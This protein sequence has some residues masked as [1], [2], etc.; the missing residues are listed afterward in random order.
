MIEIE[1]QLSKSKIFQAFRR[2][3]K[4][5]GNTIDA[6]L[7][8]TVLDGIRDAYDKSKLIIKYIPE[9][10]LHDGAHLFR[11]LYKMEKLVPDDNMER[12]S[13]PDLMLLNLTAIFHNLGMIPYEY[14]IRAWKQ[15]WET[16]EPNDE[17]QSIYLVFERFTKTYPEKMDEINRFRAKGQEEKAKCLED[18]LISEYIRKTHA[19]RAKIVIGKEWKD[20]I[21][22]S[23]TDLIQ[24]LAHIC[25]SHNEE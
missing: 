18:Y 6:Q 13:L 4:K 17:E 7:T 23:D 1:N 24:V 22:Y 2:K 5:E 21:K 14:E 3:S 15:D 11:V 8:S 10:T 19:Q 12:L 25:F 9:Y 16:E 20:R